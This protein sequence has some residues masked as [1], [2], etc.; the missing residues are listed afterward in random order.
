MKASVG[1]LA[2]LSAALSSSRTMIKAIFLLA[3]ALGAVPAMAQTITFTIY[4]D[5]S[6]TLGGTPFTDQVITCTQVTD[7]SAIVNP[8]FTYAY[9]CAPKVA[10]NTVTI[11]AMAP[12]TITDGTY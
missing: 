5:G 2:R 6:G 7:T 11:G 10:G 9:P 8:C 3:A 12:L 1:C 4:A